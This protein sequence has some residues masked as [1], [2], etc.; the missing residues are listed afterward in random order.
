L[1][2]VAKDDAVPEATGKPGGIAHHGGYQKDTRKVGSLRG[3]SGKNNP[4]KE[5]WKI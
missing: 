5:V 1:Y 2:S 3:A 4:E